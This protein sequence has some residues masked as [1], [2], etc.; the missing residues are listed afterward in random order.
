MPV[1]LMEDGTQ[2][3]TRRWDEAVGFVNLFQ[4][5]DLAPGP[6]GVFYPGDRAIPNIEQRPD[7]VVVQVHRVQRRDAAQESDLLTI[8]LYLGTRSIVRKL[9]TW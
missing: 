2:A 9:S 7:D 4:G 5:R 8:A 1:L 6:G 3:R